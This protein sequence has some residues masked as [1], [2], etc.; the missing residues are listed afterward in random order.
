MGKVSFFQNPFLLGF[1]QVEEMM[2]QLTKQ[3]GE[4]GYPPYNIEQTENSLKIILAVAGF[5]VNDLEIN[6]QDNQLT[7]KGKQQEDK[8]KIYLHR[9][10]AAR[11]FQRNFILSADLEIVGAYSEKGLLE[12]ELKRRQPDLKKQNVPIHKIGD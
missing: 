11:Q 4:S 3:A 8:D 9:G 5:A 6:L 12:I 7:I 1:E 10:I 2:I